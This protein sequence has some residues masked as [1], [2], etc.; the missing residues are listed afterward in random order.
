MTKGGLIKTI[1]KNIP[2]KKLSTTFI[3]LA[4]LFI[5]SIVL[6][7]IFNKYIVEGNQNMKAKPN[8]KE[9]MTDPLAGLNSAIKG[10]NN[11]TANNDSSKNVSGK[12]AVSN[13]TNNN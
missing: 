3:S 12:K 11:G 9:N 1:Q 7:F 4:I 5:L 8:I 6:Y 10:I 2:F 13:E